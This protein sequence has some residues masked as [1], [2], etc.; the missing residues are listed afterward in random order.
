MPKPRYLTKSYDFGGYI[1]ALPKAYEAGVKV[2]P[3]V[4]CGTCG[5]F[6]TNVALKLLE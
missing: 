5:K 6:G 2:P 4:D 3:R 1:D